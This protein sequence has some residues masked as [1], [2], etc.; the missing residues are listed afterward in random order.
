MARGYPG[1][2]G[3]H[4]NALY[5]WLPLCALFLL[6]FFDFAPA[7]EA[8]APRPARAAALL[9]LAGVLQP[10]ATSTSRCRW[11][12]RRCVYL[13]VRMLALLAPRPPDRASRAPLRLLV[14]APWL[15]L[16][17]VFLIGFRIALNVT[18]AQR[19][20]RRLRRRDRRAA[21][22]DGKPL[23][24]ALAEG[25]RT[26]RHLRPGQLRGLR[27]VRAGCSA[28]A[29]SWD[30]LPAAHA[31]A[32]AFDLLAMALLFLIGRRV[33]GPRS[34][35]RSP[36]RGPP[37][38]SRS[39]RSRATPTT[40]SSRRCVLAR[41][42][43]LARRL[44]R[45]RGALPRSP[46]LTKFA[47]LALAPLLAT[48]GAARGSRMR[49]ARAAAF[50]IAFVAVG[51]SRCCRL[52]GDDSLHT[53]YDRTIA[54]Q[55][56]RASPFS[57]WGLYGGLDGLQHG[58]ADRRRRA[59]ASAL[60]LVPRRRDAVGLAAALRGGADR[61]CSWASTTGSTCTSRGSSRW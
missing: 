29:A 41:C 30:D 38:R 58:R 26:R 11:S 3:R 1:A 59:R 39:S 15:A 50:A 19:D 51:A 56:R 8:A 22:G 28:G 23:Y 55:A 31:A 6:P 61:A 36:T 47:P 18:D 54:F 37:I 33:R 60:A 16:G 34:G 9:G 45:A 2:F 17:V 14:P 5:I 46:A 49:A 27:A 40:R 35:S 42:S 44:A 43:R 52:L 13:L 20:R 7:A 4:V 25:Q 32:I 53:F 10:R 57:V 48:H 12:T 21:S 24:G